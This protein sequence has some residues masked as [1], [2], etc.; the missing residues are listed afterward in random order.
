MPDVEQY[1]WDKLKPKSPA[2]QQTHGTRNFK[3]TKFVDAV[4]GSK[5]GH[6]KITRPALEP[7]KCSKCSHVAETRKDLDAH[8]L[9]E[10]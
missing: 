6:I 7:F 4:R 9:L 8:W 5:N 10:H 1:D 2:N 3:T